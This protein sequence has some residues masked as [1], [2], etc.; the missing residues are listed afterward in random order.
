MIYFLLLLSLFN[1]IDSCSRASS[2]S[3]HSSDLPTLFDQLQTKEQSS[4][5]TGKSRFGFVD[6]MTH[7]R[8]LDFLADQ[9]CGVYID[10]LCALAASKKL[11]DAE[12]LREPFVMIPYFQNLKRQPQGRKNEMLS[13]ICQNIY[14][15]VFG[16]LL[17]AAMCY[18]GADM[19]YVKDEQEDNVIHRPALHYALFF[20]DAPLT[21]LLLAH[22]AK[23]TIHKASLPQGEWTPLG[24]AATILDAELLIKHGA[25]VE[26]Q[27]KLQDLITPFCTG[28]NHTRDPQLISYFLSC[29]PL[30]RS[31]YFG[32]RWINL[33]ATCSAAF[34][35]EE[36]RTRLAIL[37]HNHCDYNLD[38]IE[39]RINAT[40]SHHPDIILEIFQNTIA[41]HEQKHTCSTPRFLTARRLTGR[42]CQYFVRRLLRTAQLQ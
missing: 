29:I 38:E 7:K 39:T 8:M 10:Y 11:S 42:E 25:D 5:F 34:S 41:L 35:S 14:N 24:L 36:L 27:H 2:S 18:V 12:K 30:D 17:I 22:K 23:T 9:G 28:N 3:A 21:H 6:K 1:N 33:L 19:N 31:N 13:N 20:R 26:H 16:R 40:T 15:N 32:K 37:L 4:K